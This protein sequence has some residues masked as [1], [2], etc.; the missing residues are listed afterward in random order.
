MERAAIV[1]QLTEVMLDVFDLDELDYSNS[2]GAANI[3]EWDS[4]SNIRFMV[5]AEKQFGI[6]FSNGE[7][8]GLQNVGEM[9]DLI[10][11]K[12]G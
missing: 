4:L 3:E 10:Q 12:L 5:A 8:E 11:A 9:V 7:I 1:E 2:L 6:R